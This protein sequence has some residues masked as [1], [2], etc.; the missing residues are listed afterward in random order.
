MLIKRNISYPIINIL[1]LFYL[2]HHNTKDD[3]KI[4]DGVGEIWKGGLGALFNKFVAVDQNK[5]NYGKMM[6]TKII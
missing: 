3:G 5:F 4:N 1:S 2:K 6:E